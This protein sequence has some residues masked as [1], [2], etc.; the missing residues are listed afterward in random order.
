M[1]PFGTLL[2]LALPALLSVSCNHPVPPIYQVTKTYPHDPA[3]FTQGLQFHDGFLYESTGMHG[4]SSL[5][6]VDLETGRV[7]KRVDLPARYFGEGIALVN[8]RI[9]MLTWQSG[10]GFV[11]DLASFEKREEFTYDGEGWGLA[12]D[13][14]RLLMSDG[15]DQIRFYDPS[16]FIF[17]GSVHV[18]DGETPVKALNELAMVRGELWANVWMT[19]MIVRIDP[20]SGRVLGWLDFA[21]LLESVGPVPATLDVMNGIAYDEV[22]DRILLTGKYWPWVFEV[23]FNWTALPTTSS[24]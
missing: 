18:M 8:D 19:R 3:A 23:R 2:I 16:G 4:K 9:F 15:T 22:N 1:N 17:K 11:F 21:D 12:Y 20:A 14:H 13:G 5:R 10:R 7:L 24:L 6:Q